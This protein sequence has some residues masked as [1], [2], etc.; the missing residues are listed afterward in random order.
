MN[1]EFADKES[2]SGGA[3]V[4]WLMQRITAIA[5]VPLSLRLIV[6]LDHCLNAPF[7][8]TKMWLAMPENYS[9][10][11]L[12]LV[13]VGYHAAL[14][15]QVVLED[16]IGNRALQNLLIKASHAFFGFITLLALVYL[17]RSL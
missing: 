9:W 16:Y 8:Q 17:Y 13:A 1:K 2:M 4:H 3:T 14:G 7:E 5:L 6:F 12:W 15:L 10:L 11:L